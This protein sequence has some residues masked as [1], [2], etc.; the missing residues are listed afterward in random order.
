MPIWNHGAFPSIHCL[1]GGE[2]MSLLEVLV[3]V[4]KEDNLRSEGQNELDYLAV[5][6]YSNINLYI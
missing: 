2:T 1:R 4:L 3:K 6:L 5:L